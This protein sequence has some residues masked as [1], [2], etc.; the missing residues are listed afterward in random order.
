[1]VLQ[2]I[3]HI[4]ARLRSTGADIRF[5]HNMQVVIDIQKILRVLLCLLSKKLRAPT[6]AASVRV[7]THKHLIV[8]SGRSFTSLILRIYVIFMGFDMLARDIP[9]GS[10]R[11]IN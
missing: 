2:A 10:N 5:F 4:P 1:M 11:V 9:L 7:H 3:Q 6:R 8:A